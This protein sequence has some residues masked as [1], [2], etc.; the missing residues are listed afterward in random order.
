MMRPESCAFA[1]TALQR[2]RLKIGCPWSRL[3]RPARP[4]TRCQACKR[5]A[6]QPMQSGWSASPGVP[7]THRRQHGLQAVQ[8][9]HGPSPGRQ[10][11]P[12]LPADPRRMRGGRTCWPLPREPGPPAPRP[13]DARQRRRGGRER[14]QPRRPHRCFADPAA[15]RARAAPGAADAQAAPRPGTPPP[16]RLRSPA[17]R[18]KARQPA[19]R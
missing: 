11:T 8:P 10:Q 5:K 3:T 15:A 4:R 16:R 14:V 7:A 1:R 12:A 2:L 19:A 13:A 9:K 18:H 17:R 6:L